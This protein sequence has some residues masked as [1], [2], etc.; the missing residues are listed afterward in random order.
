MS[1]YG[2]KNK[3]TFEDVEL[4]TNPNLPAWVI[5][6]KEEK[7]I[8]DRW[9][10]KAFAKCDDLIKAYVE[11]SNSYKNPFEG[12]KNCEKFNDAQLACVAQYQKKEYLDIERDIMID[13]K[14]AKKKLYKQHLKELE[15]QKAQN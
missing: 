10:K 15:A 11:C 3:K 14:I 6:P 4:P 1:E 9:R 2:N 12:I 7:V 8:F 5:T 13:E